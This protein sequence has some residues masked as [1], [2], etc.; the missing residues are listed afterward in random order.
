MCQSVQV[1]VCM[2]IMTSDDRTTERN[3][4][5]IKIKTKK[6]ILCILLFMDH[7]EQV[8]QKSPKY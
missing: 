5:K 8:R 2:H 6:V 7:L 1:R 3:H 4:R